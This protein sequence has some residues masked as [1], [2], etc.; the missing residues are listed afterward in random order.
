MRESWRLADEIRVNERKPAPSNR[1]EAYRQ[2]LDLPIELKALGTGGSLRAATLID[3]STTG[4]RVRSQHTYTMGTQ[5]AFDL[6][7]AV[8]PIKLSG[9]I[10]SREKSV[11]SFIF[12]YGLSF[13]NLSREQKDAIARELMNFQRRDAGAV[14]VK[15]Y[16]DPAK[17]QTQMRLS[18]REEVTF[19]VRYIHGQN[20]FAEGHA[21][22]ISMDG[23]RLWVD[24][25]L[26]NGARLHLTFTLPDH[27]LYPDCEPAEMP[28]PQGKSPNSFREMTTKSVVVARLPSDSR[29]LAHGVKFLDLHPVDREELARFIHT[30]QLYKLARRRKLQVARRPGPCFDIPSLCTS[31]CRE[32][33]SKK[34]SNCFTSRSSNWRRAA[35]RV[36]KRSFGG[37]PTMGR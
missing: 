18:Y 3:L 22:D 2:K 14:S 37:A 5:V 20:A 35:L 23:M 16:T 33:S 9:A 13:A 25:A 27:V 7:T 1:R 12:D 11:S 21:S 32:R 8:K 26:Q 6:P 36:P 30:L 10:V 28:R 34:N 24:T 29:K 19:P 17:D 31:G 4:C 15:K